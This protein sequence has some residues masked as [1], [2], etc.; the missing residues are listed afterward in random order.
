MN[1]GT[2]KAGLG[3]STNVAK[4]EVKKEALSRRQTMSM[5]IAPTA[6]LNKEKDVNYIPAYYMKQ[7]SEGEGGRAERGAL[8][9]ELSQQI[10]FKY[11]SIC[12]NYSS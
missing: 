10:R 11:V 9:S 5:L 8:N 7:V 1:D 6:S 2:G 3:T 12:K 4:E